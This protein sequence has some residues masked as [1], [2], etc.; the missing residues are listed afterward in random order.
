ML[1]LGGSNLTEDSQVQ[2][3]WLSQASVLVAETSIQRRLERGPSSAMSSTCV[4]Y[5]FCQTKHTITKRQRYS[6]SDVVRHLIYQLAEQHP[7]LLRSRRD[8][9]ANAVKSA[10]WRDAN[11]G[12]A[13]EVMAALLVSIMASFEAGTHIV[14]VVDRLDRCSWSDDV[15]DEWNDLD[16][17]V[18]SLLDVVRDTSLA[19]CRIVVKVLLVTDVERARYVASAM[20]GLKGRAVDWKENWQQEADRD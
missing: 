18:S 15:S 20:A 19:K 16:T 3:N 11:C 14:I 4:A 1:L 5:F 7:N 6:F 12:E 2:L 9:I 17:A 8:D 10:E 13:F